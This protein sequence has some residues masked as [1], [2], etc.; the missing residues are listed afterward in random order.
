MAGEPRRDEDGGAV[1]EGGQQRE[2]LAG[3]EGRRACEVV[4][5]SEAGH[6]SH[7]EGGGH[8]HGRPGRATQQQRLGEGHD[9]DSQVLQQRHGGGGRAGEGVQLEGHGGEEG[10]AHEA[11]VKHGAAR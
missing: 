1:A 5:H 2:S 3:P 6:A 7:G 10:R 4:P 9:D 8:G 11:A